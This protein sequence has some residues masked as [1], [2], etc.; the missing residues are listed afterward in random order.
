MQNEKQEPHQVAHPPFRI[1]HS[2]FSI[3]P[4][5][6]GSV[7]RSFGPILRVLLP[8]GWTELQ[9]QS[10]GRVFQATPAEGR[11]GGSLRVTVDEPLE[12]GPGET[13]D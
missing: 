9:Y 12:V 10:P 8:G 11:P 7:I 4:V 3:S 2:S 13:L 1:L 6:E 5:P